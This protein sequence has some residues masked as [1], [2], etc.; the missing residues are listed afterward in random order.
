MPS[1]DVVSRVDSQELENA[2]NQVKKEIDTRYDF[3]GTSASA[4]LSETEIL[5]KAES[6]MHIKSIAQMVKEK[7]SKRGIGSR[8][9]VFNPID[10]SSSG[11]FSQ[12]VKIK[13]G[14]EKDE[15]KGIVK[16]IKDA[17][18]KKIQAAV[19]G[20]EVRVTG[21]KRDDLQEAITLLTDKVDLELQFVNFR[22]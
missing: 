18:M 12:S 20:D 10:Q 5:L 9:L 13:Q 1:F 11:K 7:A 22:D 6:E 16:T 21:P 14:I 8:A 3:R 4:D 15:A 17:K 19:Q 2:I